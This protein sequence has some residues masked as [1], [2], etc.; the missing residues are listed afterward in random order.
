M[1]FQNYKTY[2]IKSKNILV[3]YLSVFLLGLMFFAPIWALYLEKQLFSITNVAIIIAINSFASVLF[4][5]PTGAIADLFGRKK[6]I[7][8]SYCLFFV[9]TIF[10]YIGGSMA[11]FVIYAI[12]FAM[13]GTLISG[14]DN[15]LIYDTLKQERKEKYYKKIIGTY[16]AIW[17]L[18]AVIGAV[19][20][21][22]LANINLSLPI[23]YTLIPFGFAIF[24]TFFLKE[25]KYP[26][27][28]NK[29]ILKHSFLSSKIALKNKQILLLSL[30]TFVIWGL[31]ESIHLMKP[32]FFDFKDISLTQ[33]GYVFALTYGLSSIGH[34]FSH[35]FSEKFGSKKTLMITSLLDPIII[36]GATF[37]IG[38]PSALL[39]VTA[40]F[41][42]GLRNPVIFDLV[43][44]ETPSKKRATVLSLISFSEQLGKIIFALFLGY[45]ADLYTINTAFKIA[46][47]MI[48]LAF[49]IVTFLK[50]QN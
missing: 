41:L 33:F 10:L 45:M 23:L 32:L 6:T 24:V 44:K 42:F 18:G 47:M 16:H 13:A 12:F 36:V 21:G 30:F 15:A 17:P 43:N 38:L 37:L 2:K 27:E 34:Y 35:D 50:K 28:K 11:I 48:V 39:L 5:I 31:G 22:Y 46:G 3:S 20:G 9:S 26:K 29:N 14:S 8:V 4:E 19:V 40:S 49:L 1:F 25:P 7:I